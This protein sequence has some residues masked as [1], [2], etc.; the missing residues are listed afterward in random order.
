MP[1]NFF[2]MFSSKSF[3]VSGLTFKSLIHF[4]LIFVY[5]V[6]LGSNFILLRVA[7]QFSQLETSLRISRNKPFSQL[8][9]SARDRAL[10]LLHWLLH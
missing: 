2:P 5:D 6:R 10:Y 3:T 4:E 8:Q 7:I 9:I 1:R